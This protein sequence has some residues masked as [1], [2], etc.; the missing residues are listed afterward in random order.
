MLRW[1]AIFF[2]IAI[3][4]AIFGFGGI[5]EGAA[6]VAKVLFFIFIIGFV[7]VIAFGATLFKK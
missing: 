2:I 7:I 1:A 5:A 6:S 3:I 4:A